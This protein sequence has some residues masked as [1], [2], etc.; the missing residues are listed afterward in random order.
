MWAGLNSTLLSLAIENW[1]DSSTEKE[2]EGDDVALESSSEKNNASI[3][4]VQEM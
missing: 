2:D 3:E 4:N 1:I